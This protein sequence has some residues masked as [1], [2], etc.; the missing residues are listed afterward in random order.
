MVPWGGRRE[1]KLAQKPRR[2]VEVGKEDEVRED[3]E[4]E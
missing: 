1:D 3:D 2:W 4:G